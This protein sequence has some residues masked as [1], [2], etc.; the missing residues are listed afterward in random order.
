[1]AWGLGLGAK[2]F[3][4]NASSLPLPP[5]QRFRVEGII[6]SKPHA[7]KPSFEHESIS[8]SMVSLAMDRGSKLFRS[9]SQKKGTP[10]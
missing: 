8:A 6:T 1:M 4:L 7:Q 10:K 3:W 5:K 2:S 9:M